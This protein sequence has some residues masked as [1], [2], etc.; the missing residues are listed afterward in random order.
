MCNLLL[1]DED[2]DEDE[3]DDEMSLELGDEDDDDSDEEPEET[4]KK[5]FRCLF[6]YVYQLK[7]KSSLISFV[8]ISLYKILL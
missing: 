1:Q 8:S 6:Y 7:L 4:P 2:E 3:D 5:V